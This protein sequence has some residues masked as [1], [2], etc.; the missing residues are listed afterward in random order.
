M[1]RKEDTNDIEINFVRVPL[2]HLQEE[3]INTAAESTEGD[4]TQEGGSKQ[5]EG[6]ERPKF[7][8][9]PDTNSPNFDFREELEKLPF[10]LNIGEAPLTLEQQKRFINIIYQN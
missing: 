7:G 10:K 4:N 6:E 9:V 8:P 5:H 1:T 2:E 3:L